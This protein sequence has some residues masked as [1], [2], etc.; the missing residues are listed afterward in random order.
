MGMN[1]SSAL[2]YAMNMAG[3][4]ETPLRWITHPHTYIHTLTPELQSLFGYL[5]NTYICCGAGGRY[6][7]ESIVQNKLLS[8]QQA[9]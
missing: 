9:F 2:K 5:G 4:R 7:V 3:I 8:Q 1:M 6:K